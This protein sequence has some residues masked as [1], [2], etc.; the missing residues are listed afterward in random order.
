MNAFKIVGL[1]EALFDVF[2]DAAHLGGAPLNFAV[3][4][5][6]LGNVGIVAS[7]V[8]RDDLGRQVLDDIRS[9]GMPTDYVQIDAA[10]PTGTVQVTLDDQNQPSY[11]I[12]RG[13]AWNAME[14]TPAYQQLAAECDAV[15]FGSLAQCESPTR[16]VIPR[17]VAAAGRAERLFDVNLRMDL[18]DEHVLARSIELA[19]AVKLNDEELEELTGMF[20]LGHDQDDA[21][22]ALRDAYDLNWVAVTRGALGTVVYDP[23]GIHRVTPVAADTANGDAVGAGD[24]TAAALL[25][26]RLRGW[27]WG[28]TIFLANTLGAFVA[29]RRGACP[30]LTDEIRNMAR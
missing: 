6:Q 27:D 23:E 9:R 15:C 4:A 13:V 7:R 17:F 1:G 19:S 2:P 12:L 28:R 30:A 29:S 24:A 10:H 21:A 20:D 18:Y 16:E 14:F 8:G 22:T 26:G 5:H 3:H 11:E 25:H